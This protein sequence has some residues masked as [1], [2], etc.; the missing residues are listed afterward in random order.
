MKKKSKRPNK[1]MS[2]ACKK[3]IAG[4]VGMEY[5]GKKE[6]VKLPKTWGQLRTTLK[7][8]APWD[9]IMQDEYK[10]KRLW[11]KMKEWV[12]EVDVPCHY[13]MEKLEQKYRDG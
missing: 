2:V 11:E 7:D 1:H 12:K 3:A 6:V 9:A 4:L 8:I 5:V 10:Y 13:Y